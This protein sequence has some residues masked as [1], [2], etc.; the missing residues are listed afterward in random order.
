MS[1][2][3]LIIYFRSSARCW[4]CIVEMM[5]ESGLRELE[6]VVADPDPG[7]R[8]TA[9]Y[10]A[11]SSAWKAENVTAVSTTMRLWRDENNALLAAEVVAGHANNR[12]VAGAI[13]RQGS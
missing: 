9:V 1:K 12:A 10:F 5:G 3:A 6:A 8:Q 13:I 11:A 4:K 2:G 7:A